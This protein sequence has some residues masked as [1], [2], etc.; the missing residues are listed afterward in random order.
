MHDVED[1]VLY[2]KLFNFSSKTII[3]QTLFIT[4]SITCSISYGVNLYLD[5]WIINKFHSIYVNSLNCPYTQTA[6]PTVTVYKNKLEIKFYLKLS[7]TC[8]HH[9]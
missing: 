9:H 5:L 3:V 7:F 2:Y 1:W 6:I 8:T 4:C